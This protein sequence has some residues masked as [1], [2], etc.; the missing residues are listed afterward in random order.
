M[1]GGDGWAAVGVLSP[2][3]CRNAWQ[4]VP[5]ARPAL[6]V[7]VLRHPGWARLWPTPGHAPSRAARPVLTVGWHPVGLR[8]WHY[9][10]CRDR[11][12]RVIISTGHNSPLTTQVSSVISGMA[13]SSSGASR[14]QGGVH[15]THDRVATASAC[16]SPLVRSRQDT[17]PA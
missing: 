8:R 9:P 6:S 15:R 2:V 13:G 5:H 4:P 1:H 14:C 16:S 11:H 3:G 7:I 17:T 10:T 12:G